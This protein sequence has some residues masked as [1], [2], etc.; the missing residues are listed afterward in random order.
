MKDHLLQHTSSSSLS[1]NFELLNLNMNLNLKY[2]VK[3]GPYQ[4]VF[5][6]QVHSLFL[7][8]YLFLVIFELEPTVKN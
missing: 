7:Q 3:G 5:G 4:K 6:G 2:A 8:L 1:S